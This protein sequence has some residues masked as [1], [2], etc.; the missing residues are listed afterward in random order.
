MNVKMNT[1]VAPAERQFQGYMHIFL[2]Q[3]PE[4]S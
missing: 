2:S 1:F 3:K 4:N